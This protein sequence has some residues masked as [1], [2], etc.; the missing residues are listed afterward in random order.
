MAH[1]RLLAY[2]ASLTLTDVRVL[3]KTGGKS[4]DWHRDSQF[5]QHDPEHEQGV[6]ETTTSAFS[7]GGFLRCR[8][9]AAS[10]RAAAPA[11]T[12]AP[13]IRVRRLMR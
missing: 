5:G 8:A 3:S 4:G 13:P 1:R 7:P 12:A 11:A 9:T 10:G 6:V 2:W